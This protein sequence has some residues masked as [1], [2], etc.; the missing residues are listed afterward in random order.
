VGRATVDGEDWILLQTSRQNRLLLRGDEAI[1]EGRR[2]ALFAPNN[3]V[4]RFFGALLPGR[5]PREIPVLWPR[6][7]SWQSHALMRRSR[8][9]VTV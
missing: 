9:A 3:V 5:H 2:S 1:Y 7:E 8:H 6:S 4:G